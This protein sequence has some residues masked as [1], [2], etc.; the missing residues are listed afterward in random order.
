MSLKRFV[1]KQRVG[2]YCENTKEDVQT[3]QYLFNA[4][5]LWKELSIEY[6]PVTGVYGPGLERAISVFQSVKVQGE[7]RQN[8]KILAPGSAT[9]GKLVEAAKQSDDAAE[10]W[11]SLTPSQ[12]ERYSANLQQLKVEKANWVPF[13]HR[14][15]LTLQA[16]L[17]DHPKALGFL[18]KLVGSN[19]TGITLVQL[20]LDSLQLVAFLNMVYRLGLGVEGAVLALKSLVGLGGQGV[21]YL[22]KVANA[23]S[24]GSLN[25]ALQA[26]KG[27]LGKIGIV[28][29]V[30]KA[31]ALFAAGQ[32]KLGFIE[33]VKGAVSL[34]VPIVGLI[35]AIF[36]VLDA[37]FPSLK[38]WPPY[39]FVRA[40]NPADLVGNTLAHVFA[41]IDLAW[42]AWGRND[43]DVMESIKNIGLILAKEVLVK[44]LKELLNLIRL[45]WEAVAWIVQWLDGIRQ[46]LLGYGMESNGRL[47]PALPP[48]MALA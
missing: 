6:F 36:S 19:E 46:S 5:G 3:V 11:N 4:A 42:T 34:A 27:V 8:Y 18:Q 24:T 32:W 47:R 44:G 9:W 10:Y 21:T 12:R 20:A 7:T 43:W 41:V 14:A 33:V 29:I 48:E 40:L 2:P 17:N 25:N 28:V 26:S 39:K 16:F 38:S 23:F 13:T 30:I 37:I 31:G 35:D 1:L 22:Q 15:G 45:G